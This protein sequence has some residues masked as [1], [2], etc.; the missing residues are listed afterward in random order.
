MEADRVIAKNLAVTQP[1][2]SRIVKKLWLAP[3]G[4]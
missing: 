2:V 4:T 3:F 1:E